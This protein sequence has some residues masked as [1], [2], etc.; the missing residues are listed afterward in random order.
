MIAFVL[1]VAASVALGFAFQT[2]KEAVAAGIGAALGAHGS[3]RVVEGALRRGG[4]RGGTALLVAAA[5]VVL[6][7]LAFVPGLGYVEAGAVPGPGARL[8]APPRPPPAGP[9]TP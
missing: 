9:R 3:G 5:A 8:G 1:A 2:W 7:A 6:A 4:T